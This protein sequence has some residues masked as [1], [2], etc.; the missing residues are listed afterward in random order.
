MPDQTTILRKSFNHYQWKN[1][2]FDGKVK[3][4]QYLFANPTLQKGL[5][6]KLQPK[7]VNETYV[8]T[9]NI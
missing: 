3:F 6:G 1:K 4:K 8:N 2:I 9:G 7:K 5:E